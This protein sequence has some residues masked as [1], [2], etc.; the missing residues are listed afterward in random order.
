MLKK[1]AAFLAVFVMAFGVFFTSQA[2]AYT[3][4]GPAS[5]RTEDGKYELTLKTT[6][7]DND[8]TVVIWDLYRVS[9]STGKAVPYWTEELKVRLCNASTGNCTSFKNLTDPL[10]HS[11]FG[12]DFT[13]M[14]PAT[15]YVDIRDP[16]PGY[17]Y[18]GLI[19]ATVQNV[20]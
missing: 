1:L 18:K 11:A 2:Y 4:F 12:A 17:Y 8:V 20:Y 14:K 9:Y 15:F 7:T 16:D 6:S 19:R 5:W 10:G 3:Q 13:N